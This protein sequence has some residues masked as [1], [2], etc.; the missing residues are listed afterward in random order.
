VLL[1][2]EE[3]SSAA[4]VADVAARAVYQFSVSDC[5][6]GPEEARADIA[7]ESS[8]GLQKAVYVSLASSGRHC[9]Q[10]LPPT[11]SEQLLSS[12]CRVGLQDSDTT[13]T[14]T[15]LFGPATR[16]GGRQHMLMVQLGGNRH[17]AEQ[18]PATAAAKEAAHVYGSIGQQPTCG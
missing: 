3:H 7:L 5:H 11:L 4:A 6:A 16:R 15:G 2:A 9:Q 10:T 8:A 17:L 18:K 1:R 14:A 12:S 13:V